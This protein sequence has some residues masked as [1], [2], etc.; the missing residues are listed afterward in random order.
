MYNKRPN[1]TINWVMYVC[2]C[3][4]VCLSVC[5]AMRFH[6]SQRI[7]SKLGRNRLR[8]MTRGVGYMLCVCTQRARV[9]AKSAH[10]CAF[11]YFLTDYVQICWEHTTTHH[12]WQGLRTLHF[13]APRARVQARMCERARD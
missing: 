10:M 5:P 12:K 8:V 11:A 7:L 2:V 3:V 6:I 13:H 4:S 9:R 1:L